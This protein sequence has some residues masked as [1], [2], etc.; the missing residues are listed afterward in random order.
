MLIRSVLGAVALLAAAACAS[1]SGVATAG[2]EPAGDQTRICRE[3]LV[4]GSNVL[5]AVCDTE[6]GW[7]DYER[8]R[9]RNSQEL[10]R[11]MQGLAG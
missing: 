6:E 2:A 7:R 4:P 5:Q 3:M 10:M 1:S 11:R 9:T 8:E